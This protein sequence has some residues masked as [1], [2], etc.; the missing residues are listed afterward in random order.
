MKTTTHLQFFQDNRL[1]RSKHFQRVDRLVSPIGSVC[2]VF[3]AGAALA[4]LSTLSSYAI[5]AGILLHFANLFAKWW[6]D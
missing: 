5:P 2:L 6:Q 3:G 1:G 4:G